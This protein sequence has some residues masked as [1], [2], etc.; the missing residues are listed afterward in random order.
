MERLLA[1]KFRPARTTPQL[2]KCRTLLSTHLFVGQRLTTAGLE[3]IRNAGFEG[4]EIFCARQHVDY[5]DTAQ[6]AELGHWFRDSPLK[7]HS[8]HSPMHSDDV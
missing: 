2:T 5:Q 8:V 3:R 7:L 4:V 1:T 6:I